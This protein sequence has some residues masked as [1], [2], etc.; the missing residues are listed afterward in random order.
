MQLNPE[1]LP[2][3]NVHALYAQV[4]LQRA[5]QPCQLRRFCTASCRGALVRE[6][7]AQRFD[8]ILRV[9]QAIVQEQRVFQTRPRRHAPFVLR[10]WRRPWTCTPPPSAAPSMA[11]T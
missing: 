2:R 3:L 11:N 6:N 4:L 9:A 1:V 7:L 10:K 5:V 8:T